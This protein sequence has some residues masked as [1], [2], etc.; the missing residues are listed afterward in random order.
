MCPLLQG[1][2]IPQPAPWQWGRWQNQRNRRVNWWWPA[3]WPDVWTEKSAGKK[4]NTKSQ[5]QHCCAEV[6]EPLTCRKSHGVTHQYTPYLFLKSV[7]Y[8]QPS[9]VKKRLQNGELI[10]WTEERRGSAELSEKHWCGCTT[11]TW[12]VSNLSGVCSTSL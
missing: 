2:S 10:C 3:W 8:F 5:C 11:V 7:F 12:L 4:S 9:R 1:R 6:S